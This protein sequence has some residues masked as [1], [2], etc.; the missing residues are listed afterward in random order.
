MAIALFGLPSQ[1]LAKSYSIDQVTIDATVNPDGSLDV[2]ENRHFDFSGK[3]NGV[4]WKL[5][6][7]EYEGRTLTITDIQ[8]GLADKGSLTPTQQLEQ[9]YSEDNDTF[10]ILDEGGSKRIKIFHRASNEGQS[11]LISYHIDNAVSVWSDCAELY[12]KFVSDGWDV[13]SNNVT[14][15]IHLPVPAGQTVT[16]GDNVRGWGHGALT[17]TVTQS[18]DKNGVVFS[19][20]KVDSADYAESRITFPQDWVSGVTPSSEARLKSIIA[21]ETA[22]ANSANERR[23]AARKYEALRKEHA[24]NFA[25]Q[26]KPFFVVS[27]PLICA[28]MVLFAEMNYGRYRRLHEPQFKG[29]YFRDVPSSDNPVVYS[30]LKNRGNAKS[31]FLTAAIM[32]LSATKAIHIDKI[33]DDDSSWRLT[34]LKY[35]SELTDPID[36]ATH[37]FLFQKVAKKTTGYI[38]DAEHQSILMSDL[39]DVAESQPEKYGEWMKSWIT[40]AESAAFKKHYFKDKNNNRVWLMVVLCVAVFLL[41]AAPMVVALPSILSDFG[42]LYGSVAFLWPVYL[43]LQ[44]ATAMWIGNRLTKMQK[45]SVDGVELS[46]KL[47]ALT[48]WFKDFTRLN[49]AVPNDVILWNKLLVI[50]VALGVSKR[51]LEQIRIALPQYVDNVDAI[52][53]YMWINSYGWRDSPLTSLDHSVATSYAAST[54]ASTFDSS[55]SGDFGGFD[56]GGSGFSGGGGGGFGGGGG[57]GAF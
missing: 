14:C 6:E 2:I 20:D 12:W 52:P 40:S 45:L 47:D 48:R 5:V 44:I 53:T 55:G 42:N 39:K 7:G 9:S 17:G 11:Y 1:A 4:Y 41:S 56:G 8:T 19:V 10:Q 43:I 38:Q 25:N 22:W 51:V 34:E 33:S 37:K 15:T 46:A 57:G 27:V 13:S 30:I 16:P 21:E 23:A 32:Q 18:N 28:L 3:F 24:I 54:I 26:T 36:Q 31:K 50:A 49:E 29:S 35:Y